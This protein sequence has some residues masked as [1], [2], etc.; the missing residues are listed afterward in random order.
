MRVW[1]VV[2]LVVAVLLMG[3][4][5]VWSQRR[6]APFKVS[7]FLEADEIRV[8]SRVGGRVARVAVE[9]GQRVRAGDVL[10]ELDPYDLKERRSEAAAQ[11]AARKAE[12]QRLSSGFRPE[13]IAQA[14]ARKDQ[15]EANLARLVAGPRPEEIAAAE[16]RVREAEAGLELAQTDYERVRKSIESGAASPDEMSRATENQKSA[17]AILDARK[18]ELAELKAGYRTEEVAEARA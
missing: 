6:A 9:E 10:V 7:G 3:A 5:L 17:A 2:V 13:E 16:A 11:V 1:A 18:Q 4:A 8:G 14:K 15:A 12:F